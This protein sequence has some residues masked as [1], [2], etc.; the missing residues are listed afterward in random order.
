M[1]REYKTC[2]NGYVFV[3][4]SVNDV[5]C[6]CRTNYKDHLVLELFSPFLI[7]IPKFYSKCI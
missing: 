1:Q 5:W 4:D 2:V 3:L 7:F 6:S